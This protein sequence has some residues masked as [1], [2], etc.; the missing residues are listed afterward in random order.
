[1]PPPPVCPAPRRP[2][3]AT[4]TLSLMLAACGGGD[5][6]DTPGPTP[7]PPPVNTPEPAPAPPPVNTPEPA[8]APPPVNAPEPAPAPPAPPPVTE[9]EPE[10]DIGPGSLTSSATVNTIKASEITEALHS[11]ESKVRE[12]I[13]P[14]YDVTSYRLTYMTTD[15]NGMPVK[16]SGLVS[17]PIKTVVV[18]SPVLSYQHAT[19]FHDDQAPSRKVEA[20]EPPLVLASLGYIVV[21]PDYVGFGASKGVEH[22][23]LTATPAARAV[24]D[25]LAAAQKWRLREGVADN[26]QLFLVGYSE[27]GYATIAA[28]RALQ[29]TNSSHLRQLVS[30][31]PGAG[32]YHVGVTLDMQL[33]RVRDENVLIAG[34]I[35]PGFLRYLGSKVRNEVR[36]LIMRLVVPDDADVTFQSTFLDNFLADDAAATAQ[37]LFAVLR[38]FDAQGAR[39]I[40]IETPPDTPEWEAVRDRLQR[41]AAA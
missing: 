34:L 28:H 19:T 5:D 39:L 26:G 30:S 16:A 11:P 12:G 14:R 33:Q 8:P 13:A 6:E 18:A 9:P 1:M 41:A 3:L 10:P 32:P 22:P 4:L 23:Y 38:E 2:L 24:I 40:W 25:M 7:A 21:S 17:V 35:S 15:K 36:R 37:Q 29:A 27:G 31:I 20:V